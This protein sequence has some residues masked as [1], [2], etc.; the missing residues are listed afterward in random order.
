MTSPAQIEREELFNAFA[1]RVMETYHLI[2]CLQREASS[3]NI[4][5]V[6]GIED[7]TY[8]SVQVSGTFVADI[9]LQISNDGEHWVDFGSV[10][11]TAGITEVDLYSAQIRAEI[12]NYVSG[13]VNVTLVAKR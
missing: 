3:D 13:S 9:Q 5:E 1:G 7:F 4:G 2:S 6:H 8:G 10:I 12:D 11:T